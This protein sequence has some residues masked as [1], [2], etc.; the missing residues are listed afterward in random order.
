VSREVVDEGTSRWV[1]ERFVSDL[2][3]TQWRSCRVQI[4]HGLGVYPCALV[5]GETTAEH[6]GEL[7]DAV[8]AIRWGQ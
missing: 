2:G 7:M 6:M 8:A 1:H 4:V 3:T 5:H